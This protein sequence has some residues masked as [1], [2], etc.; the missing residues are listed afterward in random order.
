ML[1]TYLKVL[2]YWFVPVHSAPMPHYR[3]ARNI[4]ISNLGRWL[5]DLLTTE[6]SELI[7]KQLHYKTIFTSTFY[8]HLKL[9]TMKLPVNLT[10]WIENRLI[11]I[12]YSKE[13][14]QEQDKWFEFNFILEGPDI[15][16]KITGFDCSPC[17]VCIL[18]QGK[19]NWLYLLSCITSQ[20]VRKWSDDMQVALF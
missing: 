13:I 9:L 11:G 1:P 5:W 18:T 20:Q 7:T 15:E 16:L 10:E 12:K 17:T 8:I 2:P 4:H 3:G 6:E 19:S 14:T